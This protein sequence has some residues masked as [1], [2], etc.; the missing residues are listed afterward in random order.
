MSIQTS[1]KSA[2]G[3]KIIKP[4]RLPV[5]YG[6]LVAAVVTIGVLLI[7]F[8]NLTGNPGYLA[9]TVLTTLFSFGSLG[10]TFS[11][12]RSRLPTPAKWLVSLTLWGFVALDVIF[13]VVPLF[14]PGATANDA[15]PF[16]S[17]AKP[18]AQATVATVVAKTTETVLVKPG[19]TL[20][21]NFN[22]V[23]AEPVA[24]KAAL[25]KTGDGKAVLRLE[26]FKAANGPDLFVYL[27]KEANPTSAQVKNGFEV[28]KL[29]ATQG[30]LNYDL[31]GSF[32]LSQYKSVVVYCKSFSAV[33]GFAN[34]G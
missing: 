10:L 5:F 17:S 27:T 26:N 11:G 9:L 29:K 21:G 18:A 14:A 33:F 4:L 34:L 3:P 7:I 25:G 13:L 15:D 20:S 2:I 32:D 19:L 22:N 6:F 12:L 24:G 31:D 23:G 16:A 28:G 8:P 1:Q 30:N